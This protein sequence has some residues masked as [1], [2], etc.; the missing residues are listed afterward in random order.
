M[1]KTKLVALLLV[2]ALVASMVV[3]GVSAEGVYTISL[4]DNATGAATINAAA[5]DTITLKMELTNN[6][7]IGAIGVTVE[8]PEGW[9]F[10]STPV[11]KKLFS[12]ISNG[13]YAS[14]QTKEVNPY[15]FNWY[16]AL[17]TIENEEYGTLEGQQVK[18]DGV[19]A[20]M[21][22]KV[23]EDAASGTYTI[24][25]A[26][27]AGDNFSLAT[28]ADG[29][30]IE[31]G[32]RTNLDVKCE[33][34]TIVVAGNEPAGAA[35]PE[36]TD[37]TTW[38]E[39]AENAWAA[40]GE[41]ATGHYKL[42]GNQ[43]TTAALTVAEGA[44][45]CIDL[46]GHN[47][48]AG[49]KA[50]AAS[51]S[52]RV[53]ENAGTLTILD[54]TA[55]GA[56]ETYAAGVISG[57]AMK[58]QGS[59]KASSTTGYGGN[60]LN[61]GTFTLVNGI[62]AD[63]LLIGGA[64]DSGDNG[65][66]IYCNGGV[67]N[68]KGGIVRGGRIN[69]TS[70]TGTTQGGGNIYTTGTDVN[71]TGG[72]ITDGKIRF[73]DGNTEKKYS[74]STTAAD[75][76]CYLNG[77]NLCIN[78]GTLDIANAVISDGYIVQ[79]YSFSKAHVVITL[80]G[81]NI[82]VNNADTNIVNSTISGG[83]LSATAVG[84][85]YPASASLSKYHANA[86]AQGG[87]IYFT[88]SSKTLNI[89]KDT[90]ITGGTAVASATKHA[91]STDTNEPKLN[92][93]HRGGNLYLNSGVLNLYGTMTNG[94]AE[95][96]GAI[97]APG[98]GTMNIFD[99]AYI[100][101]NTS[102]GAYGHAIT[103][104]GENVPLNIY[105]GTITSDKTTGATIYAMYAPVNIYGGLVESTANNAI[106][107]YYSTSGKC[108]ITMTDGA[109]KG[110]VVIAENCELHLNGG[111]MDGNVN[112]KK[113]TSLA[114]IAA[115]VTT[116][117]DPADHL[118]SVT[119]YN[120]TKDAQDKVWYVTYANLAAAV[121][122]AKEGD[123]IILGADVTA[124]E[125]TVPADVTLDLNGKNLTATSITSATN[126]AHIVDNKGSGQLVSSDMTVAAGN[127]QLPVK[128]ASGNYHFE[129]LTAEKT[130]SADKKEHKFYIANEADKTVIDEA[131]VKGYDTVSISVVIKYKKVGDDVTVHE[132]TIPLTPEQTMQYANN[133]NTAIIKLNLTYN[134]NVVA[135]SIVCDVVIGANN[136]LVQA[137][138]E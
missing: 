138:A 49:A 100:A 7:G 84:A 38:N 92:A 114:E 80:L 33:S 1:R 74:S 79:S 111:V 77:G 11:N 90:V 130:A 50:A 109:I 57:G 99:G 59:S 32:N 134:E 20:T 103:Y 94:S 4:L 26:P 15:V 44:T 58:N 36:H 48:T 93:N 23:P 98:P 46:N 124:D 16:E 113:T 51:V 63:G 66:N 72:I 117:F 69:R 129:T 78:G 18:L 65:A 53:F 64:Y 123:K 67:L 34:M 25:L 137:D 95:R 56:G 40:G 43:A 42:T 102:T 110:N 54:T 12:D 127:N 115:G 37:V 39:I 126:G 120:Q 89:D 121:D 13:S 75:R 73:M 108:V 61:T 5:G 35:C 116:S 70:Q 87:N 52:Y 128:N 88:N 91:D 9:T 105:G 55:T 28:D 104:T 14:S 112:L 107:T 81:G 132:K 62:I 22:I 133:W 17:G 86:A 97:F 8:R 85:K 45:V 10:A 71:I 47:I 101:D 131:I 136:A 135:D 76:K 118:A 6:P 96:G 60:I 82:Y 24:K 19:L 29:F 41:L 119:A 68:I 125:V 83:Y 122:A 106:N 3:P 2:V 21:K 27:K 30:I 31:G